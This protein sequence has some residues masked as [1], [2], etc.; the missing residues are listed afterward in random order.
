MVGFGVLGVHASLQAAPFK[1]YAVGFSFF[2][3]EGKP[4]RVSS[5]P[6]DAEELG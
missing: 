3:M 6:F 1:M 2:I 5:P 4:N